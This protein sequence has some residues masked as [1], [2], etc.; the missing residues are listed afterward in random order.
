MQACKPQKGYK[1]VKCSSMS[2][3]LQKQNWLDAILLL[4]K[5]T[6]AELAKKANLDQG[7]IS[8]LRRDINRPTPETLNAIAQATELPPEVVFRKAGLLPQKESTTDDW[9]IEIAARIQKLPAQSRNA[10]EHLIR[11]FYEQEH[12]NRKGKQ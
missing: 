2:E 1:V 10:V 12:G 3:K 11:Y 5:M 7:L 4:V 6:P 9:A 8:R